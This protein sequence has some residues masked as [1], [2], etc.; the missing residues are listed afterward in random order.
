M[1]TSRDLQHEIKEAGEMV[2]YWKSQRLSDNQRALL[3]AVR[4]RNLEKVNRL[5]GKG[6]DPNFKD[7]SNAYLLHIITGMHQQQGVTKDILSSVLFFGADV[8]V[9]DRFGRSPL[10]IASRSYADYVQTL[11]AIGCD[12]NTQD[13]AGRTALMEACS[14]DSIA[15]LNIVQM[16]LDHNCNALLKDEDGFTALHCICKNSKQDIVVRREIVYKLL[17]AGTSATVKD[18]SGKMPLCYELDKF[19]NCSRRRRFNDV[20]FEVVRTLIQAGANYTRR[21]KT[22]ERWVK[23]AINFSQLT[24]LKQLLELMQPVL[25]LA[26]L[27]HLR[28]MCPLIGNDDQDITKD[29]QLLITSVSSLKS[30]CRI[31]IRS[32]LKGDVLLKSELL[33]LPTYLKKYLVLSN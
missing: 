20:E 14:S 27:K 31:V 6:T 26:S 30:Q 10:H 19:V 24:F 25:S 18:K 9:R 33:P 7:D 1:A 13:N 21:N 15:A 4:K 17:L 29:I 2:E 12:V 8:D 23:Y 28:R 11:L 3:D 5:L 16:L 32:E 22:H